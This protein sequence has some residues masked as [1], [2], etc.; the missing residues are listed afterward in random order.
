ME[1]YNYI[2]YI[3]DCKYA[4]VNSHQELI[5]CIAK[6]RAEHKE[7]SEYTLTVCKT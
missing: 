6:I 7:D 1:N 4:E 3:N 5:S 2:I